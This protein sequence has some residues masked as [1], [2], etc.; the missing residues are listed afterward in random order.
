MDNRSL[1][2]LVVDSDPVSRR[3]LAQSIN[4]LG[5]HFLEACDGEDGLAKAQ[6]FRPDIIITA[7]QMPVMDGINLAR[8]LQNSPKTLRPYII[9]SAPREDENSL[10]AVLDE[11]GIDNFL[12]QPFEA[13]LLAAQLRQGQRFIRLQQEN[14]RLTLELQDHA[15]QLARSNL[16]FR[17]LAITDELTGLPN[18]RYAM[19]R[20]QQEWASSNRDHSALSCLLIDLD[21]LKRINN[22]LGYE[23]GDVI[24][25]T[26]AA[27]TKKLLR[28][29]DTVCRVGGDEFLVISPKTPLAGA[30]I[31]AGRL[32]RA[33]ESFGIHAEK[34][35]FSLSIGVVERR[36]DINS[37][38]ALMN[39]TERSL[40]YAKRHGT[41]QIGSIQ[42]KDLQVIAGLSDFCQSCKFKG[43]AAR[44]QACIWQAIDFT[45][46]CA[47]MIQPLAEMGERSVGQR[48][49]RSLLT[50]LVQETTTPTHDGRIE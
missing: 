19:E 20:L 27:L 40:R 15:D 46:D 36:P 34:H 47:T 35:S 5:C 25:K 23:R 44:K 31:C 42:D 38:Q 49:W 39:L 6:E 24:L 45:Q 3:L 12:G 17:E 41:N 33:L 13:T 8:T 16:R 4:P 22:A 18:R 48:C 11:V 29:E 26:I 2:I 43:Q 50:L 30:I 28:S 9:L 14:E 7:W 10:T 1:R 32:L 21:G 37:P